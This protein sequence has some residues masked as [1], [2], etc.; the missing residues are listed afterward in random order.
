MSASTTTAQEATRSETLVLARPVPRVALGAGEWVVLCWLTSLAILHGL[1]SIVLFPPWQHHDEPTHF[2][3]AAEVAA[4][5]VDDP[6]GASLA[7]RREIADSMYRARF[8]APEFVPNVLL[9]DAPAIGFTQR[10]HPPLYYGLVGAVLRPLAALSIETQ[11]YAARALSLALYTLTV[12]AAWRVAVTL[13][14]DEPLIQLAIPLLTLLVPSF[15]DIMTAVNNDVLLN[16]SVTVALLGAVLLVRDGPRPLPLA[17]CL[18]GVAVGA[19]TKRTALVAVIPLLL[20]FVW[21][22]ARA[23]QRWW[24]LPLLSLSLAGV[25]AAATLQPQLVTEPPPPHTVLAVRPWVDA[26]GR[27]YLRT[28]V[29]SLVRSLSDPTLIGDRYWTLVWVAFSGY[30]THFAWGNVAMHPAWA[31]SLAAMAVVALGGLVAA[32][33]PSVNLPLWQR[34]CLWVFLLSVILAWTS[35]FVRLHPLPPLDQPVYIP[36]ARYMFWA[37]VPTLWLFVTGLASAVP[38]RWRRVVVVGL[39]AF[40]ACLNLVAWLWTIIPYY[41]G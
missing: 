33:R 4:G 32:M 31:A 17:L 15:A 28:P 25:A 30:Y 13:A 22:V 39:L 6:G 35:L 38:E 18:L 26:L 16:F 36:R 40:F 12:L 21:A 14:P 20:A 5:E 19:M 1:L 2:L 29:D 7:L 41:Y 10:V 23:P 27:D 37:L 24:L 34:R 9:P 3:Y 11:L 8:F